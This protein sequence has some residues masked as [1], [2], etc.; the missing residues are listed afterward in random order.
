VILEV[1]G[2][3]GFVGAAACLFGRAVTVL[4]APVPTAGPAVGFAIELIVADIAIQLPGRAVTAGIVLLVLALASVAICLRG[5]RPQLSPATIPVLVVAV[6]GSAVPFIA[7]GRVGLL[8]VGLDNDTAYHLLWA[9]ALRS[10]AVAR[11]RPASSSYPLAPHSLA[12]TVATCL[13][14]RLDLAFDVFM[15]ATIIVTAL[16]AAAA[17]RDES[18]WRR[19]LTSAVA[20]FFYL[21]AA[22]YG[23]N[24][25]KE[26]IL[27]MLLLGFV[28]QTEDIRDFWADRIRPASWSSTIPL[29]VLGVAGIYDF[30]YL[31]AGWFLVTLAVWTATEVVVSPG[32]LCA[33]SGHLREYSVRLGVAVL[34]VLILLAPLTDRLINLFGTFGVSPA[35]AIPASNIGNLATALS[36]YEGLG[37]WRS[38]DF[39]FAPPDVFHT[40]ELG[41]FALGVLIFGL[42]WAL[43][44]RRFVMSAGVVACGLLYLYSAHSQSAYV[45]AKS[46]AIA[47]PVFGLAGMRGLLGARESSWSVAANWVRVAVA[48]LFAVFA[49]GS[50]LLVLRDSPVY[51]T[52]PVGE[53]ESFAPRVGS[54]NVLFLG[55]S[56]YGAWIFDHAHLA[57]P[58]PTGGGNIGFI[59]DPDKPVTYGQ[60]YDWDSLKT[61]DLNNFRWV[62]TT[63]TDYQSQPPKGFRLVKK[64]QLYELWKR[65]RVV[66]GRRAIDLPDTPGR[67]LNCRTK[68]GRQISR[69]HGVAAIMVTP[70]TEDL[71]TL[72]PGTS[73]NVSLKLPPGRWQLSMSYFSGVPVGVSAQG[74]SWTMPAYLDRPGPIFAVGDVTSRGGMLPIRVTS[75]RPSFLTIEQDTSQLALLAATR[76]PDTRTVVPL[77]EACGRYV[78][79]YQLN[80]AR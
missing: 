50:S 43:G 14:V 38:P 67:L 77:R 35:A 69:E 71:S 64:L 46:L 45:T 42:I 56:D 40:G 52:A 76:L 17:L 11:L 34:A 7:N 58:A 5:S 31:A 51:P 54:S 57:T 30:G 78:D 27:G 29:A 21:F 75:E 80:G 33:L 2:A 9:D 19:L 1:W 28:L 24:S 8:G 41:A 22:Y 16:V 15:I 53:L 48:V 36:P 20:A 70:I 61:A 39:R 44:H 66:P 6:I 10:G 26:V 74:H 59:A 79:W 62:I 65:V 32:I 18:W 23:E 37:I 12:A 73:E 3:T 13:G 72:S 47:G 55:A 68:A 4:G 49:L 60:E 25:F 63:S